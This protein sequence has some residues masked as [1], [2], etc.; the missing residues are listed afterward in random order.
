MKLLELVVQEY[1]SIIEALE[2]NESVENNRIVIS[3]EYFQ[4]L[5]E[6]YNYIKFRDKTKIYKQLN[7][8][9]HDKNNYTMPCKD[10]EKNKTIRK[11]VFNYETFLVVKKLYKENAIL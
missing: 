10:K 3:R 2:V 8:I 4:K 9:I 5:L 7:F 6:Q 11:V 1:I